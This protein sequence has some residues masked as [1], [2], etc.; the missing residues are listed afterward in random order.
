M[1]VVNNLEHVMRLFNAQQIELAV[2]FFKLQNYLWIKYCMNSLL[3]TRST[4]LV[5]F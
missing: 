2:S 4:P 5:D 1:K 3:F